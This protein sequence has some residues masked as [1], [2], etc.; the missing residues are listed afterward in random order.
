MKSLKLAVF[1]AVLAL[2]VA[3]AALAPSAFGQAAP[4]SPPRTSDGKPDFTGNWTN[5]SVTRMERP[6]GLPLVITREQADKLEGGALFNVRSAQKDA[7]FVD[8]N[9]P[10][11]EKGKPLP[12]VGNYDVAY[13]DPGAHVLNIG[14]EL[15][16]S[17][18]TFPE[19]GRIPAMTEEGKA[20]RASLAKPRGNGYD[21]PE[22][23]G[24]SERCVFIGT[25]GPPLGNYLYNNNFHIM[26]TK[27][28]FVLQAEMI[29]DT[30]IA[31]I[32]GE[33]RKDGVEPWMGDS[34]AKWEG[35]TLVVETTNLNPQQR[36]GRGTFMSPT[37]KV[38]ER[39]T[40]ISDKQI[41]YAFEIVDPKVYASNWQGEMALNKMDGQ[42]YEY[43]C[44]EG[45]YGLVSILQGGRRND[46]KGI[47]NL[48][49][50]RGE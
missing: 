15:R 43:A 22:E 28:N 50:S 9:A 37:G 16:S 41:L 2:G 18:I 32:G 21:N 3:P 33:H 24:L 5:A 4:Y 7:S 48:S 30:R 14:G 17:Y 13:T 31:R 11:P 45:N 36:S 47:K 39:F 35:D 34:T 19:N 26:Q 42:V 40:R 44:H 1:S 12:G 38:I 46:R 6:A 49:G 10:A 27:D 20:L 29:H 25:P 23:R 8:P